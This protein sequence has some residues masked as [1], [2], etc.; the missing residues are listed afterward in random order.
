MPPPAGPVDKSGSPR[1]GHQFQRCLKYF[2]S[3]G[4][5]LAGR[6]QVAVAAAV[7]RLIDDL[8]KLMVARAVIFLPERVGRGFFFSFVIAAV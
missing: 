2:R 4:G 7:V 6:H 1:P 5:C 3:A 8:D